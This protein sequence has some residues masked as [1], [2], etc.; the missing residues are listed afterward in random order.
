[1]FAPNDDK[2]ITTSMDKSAKFFDLKSLKVTVTVKYVYR[3]K[4]KLTQKKKALFLHP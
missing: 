4:K 3:R 2:V 1:M